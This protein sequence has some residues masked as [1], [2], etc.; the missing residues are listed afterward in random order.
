MGNESPRPVPSQIE[1]TDPTT[2]TIRANVF[3]LNLK[4]KIAKRF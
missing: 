3:T 2:V 4:D 1:E